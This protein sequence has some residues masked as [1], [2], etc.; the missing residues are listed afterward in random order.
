MC[1]YFVSVFKFD[2]KYRIRQGTN[3]SSERVAR[4][5]EQ[6]TDRRRILLRRV[7]D[8]AKRALGGIIDS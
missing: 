6:A 1:S 2:F 7:R 4:F 8:L 3:Q 5:K